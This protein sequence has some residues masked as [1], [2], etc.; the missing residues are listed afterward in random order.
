MYSQLVFRAPNVLDDSQ[1]SHKAWMSV[2]DADLV[3]KVLLYRAEHAQGTF[4]ALEWGS[5]KST[6]YFTNLLRE[7]GLDFNWLTLEYDRAFFESSFLEFLKTRDRVRVEYLDEN[8]R[9]TVLQNSDS[10]EIEAAV[11]DKGKLSPFDPNHAAD[12][13]VNLDQYVQYP[14]TLHKKFDFILVDGRHRRRC[15]LEASKLLKP[16][17]VA[18]LHDAYREYYHCAFDAFRSRRAIGDILFIGAQY[19]TD[20]EEFLS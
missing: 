15:L 14:A 8:S 7:R 10:F 5:G 12:R 20:F 17:G 18:F 2:T 16:R 6:T 19:E 3:E 1:W 11:F 13:L 4:H 9:A